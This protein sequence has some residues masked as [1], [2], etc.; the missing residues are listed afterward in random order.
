MVL[1]RTKPLMAC[2][3]TLHEKAQNDA[4]L[5]GHTKQWFNERVLA[6]FHR[7]WLNLLLLFLSIFPRGVI[8]SS[9]PQNHTKLVLCSWVTS[10]RH[11][12]N[13]SIHTSSRQLL[14]VSLWNCRWQMQPESSQMWT[15]CSSSLTA[16][17]S[18]TQPADA[19][20][21]TRDL[22]TAIPYSARTFR[23]LTGYY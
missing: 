22:K 15:G 14:P 1:D 5:A 18:L 7:G 13:P 3:R 23:A 19:H 10:V 8:A 2:D 17:S 6:N 11:C 12:S 20:L 4:S 16:T 9:H 21:G